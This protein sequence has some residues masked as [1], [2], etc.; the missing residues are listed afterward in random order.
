MPP[1]RPSLPAHARTLIAV[2][3][4]PG[5]AGALTLDAW[6]LLIR[7]ARVAR[8]LGVLQAVLEGAGR[9][10]AVPEPVRAHL[11]AGRRQAE[12]RRQMALYEADCV[13]S[14]LA[15]A[16]I[17]TVL[18]KGAAYAALG[19]RCA[20]GRMPEDLDILVPRARLAEAEELLRDAGWA[21]EEKDDYD[22]RYYREW[23]HELP[24]LRFPGHAFEL[25]LHHAIV[26][27]IARHP[28]DMALVLSACRP[29]PGD[30]RFLVL[31]P[32]DQVLHAALHLF[33][34][35]CVD[36][37]RDLVDLWFLLEE[38]GARP[39]FWDDLV[40][41][42]GALPAGRPL[43]YALQCLEALVG[44]RPPAAVSA[45]VD[46]FAPPRPA[47]WTMLRLL[48][49]CLPPL[50]PDAHGDRGRWVA[51]QAL[52]ARA[53]WLRFPVP[54]LARHLAMKGIRSLRGKPAPAA[55]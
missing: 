47:A 49:T 6:D 5:Q 18:L 45:A 7:T 30:G 46:R 12:Y 14:V 31:S 34:D 33:Q 17:S 27:P 37:L 11:V 16:G 36:R 35:E 23:S 9:F 29:L 28:V 22:E 39:G 19:L 13:A 4:D 41:R 40:G 21:L 51:R 1:A 2:L 42:A 26:P 20:V 43:W 8:L 10:D 3:A 15:P 48:A 25:D 24:P 55:P 32:A 38:L 50:H 52:L 54:I 53:L 44:W